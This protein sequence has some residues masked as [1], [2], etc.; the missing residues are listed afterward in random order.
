[1]PTT[2]PTPTLRVRWMVAPKYL[3]KHSITPVKD[4]DWMFCEYAP[5]SRE[6][7][8]VN[9]IVD[10]SSCFATVPT[11]WHTFSFCLFV[12]GGNEPDIRS[13]PSISHLACRHH[14]LNLNKNVLGQTSDLDTASSGL[15]LAKELGVDLV[16]G[17]KVVHVLDEDADFEDVRGGGVGRGEDGRDVLEDLFLGISRTYRILRECNVQSAPRHRRRRSPWS[18][19]RGGWSRKRR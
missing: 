10:A 1:M 13:S 7:R 12:L 11:T 5:G 6:V 19:G 14:S 9:L 16:D 4:T 3:E 17:R 8:R 15:G 18:W 2:R